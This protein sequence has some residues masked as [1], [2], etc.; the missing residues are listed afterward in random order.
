MCFHD[1]VRGDD[2]YKKCVL[3]DKELVNKLFIHE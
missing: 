3:N 2:G 1:M